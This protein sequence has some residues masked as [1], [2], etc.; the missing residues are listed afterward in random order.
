M[1]QYAQPADPRGIEQFGTV[2]SAPGLDYCISGAQ[3][4]S[5]D[6][7]HSLDM[8]C[9]VLGDIVSQTRYHD[10]PAK[11]STFQSEL[12]LERRIG[13]AQQ[14]LRDTALPICDVAASCGF[15]PQ[16]HMTALFSERLGETPLR[17]R[18]TAGTSQTKA[19]E[20]MPVGAQTERPAT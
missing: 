7:A 18:K 15:S 4:Y 6:F 11:P 5:A 3:P 8:I 12:V 13:L 9:L 14:L 10:G 16:Q 20:R 2:A 1:S 19:H 17:V